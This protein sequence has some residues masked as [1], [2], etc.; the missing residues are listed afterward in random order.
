LVVAQLDKADREALKLRHGLVEVGLRPV[1]R[2][3]PRGLG[4]EGADVGRGE[5]DRGLDAALLQVDL[6]RAEPG[7]VRMQGC[8][9]HQP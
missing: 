6:R 9:K 2:R 5:A 4:E 1:A 8:G 7:I 3:G